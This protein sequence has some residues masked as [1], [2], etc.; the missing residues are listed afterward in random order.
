MVEARCSSFNGEIE[1]L[2]SIVKVELP[3]NILDLILH[4]DKSSTATTYF[5]TTFDNIKQF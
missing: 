3:G 4:F 5:Q 2:I 1:I